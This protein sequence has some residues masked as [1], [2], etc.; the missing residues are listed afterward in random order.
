MLIEWK[1]SYRT[2]IDDVD[3]EHRELI[4]L[5]NELHAR[6][7]DPDAPLTVPAFFGDLNRAITAHFALEERHMRDRKYDQLKEHKGEHERLLDEIRDIMDAY[8]AMPAADR[9]P[10]LGKT[11][12][13][14]F[15]LHFRT[16]DS[17]L[18]KAL[19]A[20]PHE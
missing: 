1:D 10:F 18:H 12:D 5:I 13:D 14:W 7:N 4:D 11:L 16:H 15:T 19:G 8:E 3:Y 20:H 6:L 17:R 2:G 9:T